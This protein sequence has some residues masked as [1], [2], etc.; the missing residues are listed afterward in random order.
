[1]PPTGRPA[2][3]ARALRLVFD[4]APFSRAAALA[5]GISDRALRSAID[6]GL[7]ERVGHGV[8]RVPSP[9]SRSCGD[10]GP[11]GRLGRPAGQTAEP[12]GGNPRDMA[13]VIQAALLVAPGGVVSLRTAP[14]LLLLPSPY[15]R[16]PDFIHL[17]KTGSGQRQSLAIPGYP[18]LLT[19]HH[20]PMPAHHL[21]T[22][23]GLPVTTPER[24]ALDL[25]RTLPLPR[26]LIVID[27]VMRRHVLSGGAS[28]AR[29]ETGHRWL[30][31]DPDRAY[32]ARSQ[33]E[34]VARDQ[35]GWPGIIRARIAI[36]IGDPASESPLESFARGTWFEQG[37][38]LPESGV[39]ITGADGVTYWVDQCWREQGVIVELDGMFK[40]DDPTALRSEKL[41][42]EA[43]EE[44]GWIVVRFTW[45][46]LRRDPAGCAA[47]LRSALRRGQRA[48]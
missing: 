28:D 9:E 5:Q 10:L 35:A 16:D 43:L 40:Y 7:V 17:N 42:Q 8:M 15:A 25:A 30:V 41:R 2:L 39:P 47:R 31:R 45:E 23:S 46:Q 19:V 33:L 21:T 14:P 29:D 3:T 38:P 1:M 4:D 13:A 32:E 44:A 27:A 36:G 22:A 34:S 48:E 18:T 12:H 26:S 24:T 6:R 11:Q 20:S 37:L